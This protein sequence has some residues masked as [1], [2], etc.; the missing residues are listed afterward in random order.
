M[1]RI[2]IK[3]KAIKDK[4]LDE[5]IKKKTYIPFLGKNYTKEQLQTW[6]D[7][8]VQILERLKKLNSSGFELE[9]NNLYKKLSKKEKLLA[10]EILTEGQIEL[11]EYDTEEE[12]ENLSDIRLYKFVI[13]E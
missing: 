11:I 10:D 9:K 12:W 4:D 6:L 8:R 13:N 3:I 5:I 2:D 7:K 1:D